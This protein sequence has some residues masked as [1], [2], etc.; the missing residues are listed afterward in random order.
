MKLNKNAKKERSGNKMDNKWR[1]S[2][3]VEG[4]TRKISPNLAKNISLSLYSSAKVDTNEKEVSLPLKLY[5]DRSY[6]KI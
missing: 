3:R 1:Q 4:V 6:K 2:K 5:R